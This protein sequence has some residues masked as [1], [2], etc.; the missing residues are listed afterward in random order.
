MVDSLPFRP[1][2]PKGRDTPKGLLRSPL[3]GRAMAVMEY[4][5]NPSFG[6]D[7]MVGLSAAKDKAKKDLKNGSKSF[8][9]FGPTGAGKSVLALAM[10]SGLGY[11]IIDVDT[12]RLGKDYL[13]VLRDLVR[14]LED[15]R[16]TVLL[17]NVEFFLLKVSVNKN[18]LG[19]TTERVIIYDPYIDDVSRSIG[20]RVIIYDPYIDYDKILEHSNNVI[21]ILR[22]LREASAYLIATSSMPWILPRTFWELFESYIYVSLPGYSE[23]VEII[24]RLIGSSMRHDIDLEKL[25]VYTRGCSVSDLEELVRRLRDAEDPYRV[26]R[27]YR[28]ISEKLLEDLYRR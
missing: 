1:W 25:A 28:C 26:L 10:A 12:A 18:I 7:D 3:S 21:D 6:L 14:Y 20:Q 8:L 5:E 23:R 9:I 4:Y 19:E 22:D 2:S 15:R 16:Y 13:E 11:G 17:Y 27:D 24:K